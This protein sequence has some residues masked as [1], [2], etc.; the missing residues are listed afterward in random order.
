M[1]RYSIMKLFVIIVSIGI[2]INMVSHKIEYG[3]GVLCLILL[4]V[5]NVLNGISQKLGK[6]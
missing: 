4:A 5:L 3:T 2:L 1:S 6:D